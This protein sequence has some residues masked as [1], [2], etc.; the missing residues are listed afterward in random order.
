VSGHEPAAGERAP[1][2]AARL[3]RLRHGGM[4]W[5]LAAASVREVVGTERLQR[6]PRATAGAPHGWLLGEREELP[7]FL[8]AGERLATGTGAI[9]VVQAA[10]GPDCGLAVEAVEEVREEPISRLRLLPALAAARRWA[11]PRVVLWDDGLALEIAPEAVPYLAGTAADEEARRQGP[12]LAPPAGTPR[13]EVPP[14]RSSS[15]SGL[16]LFTLPGLPAL[17]CA[18]PAA[19]VVEVMSSFPL[20]PVPGVP[21][22]F[23]GLC[24][25]RG[26]PLP[27][28]DLA[29][30][31]G[32]PPVAPR[33]RRFAHGLVARAAHSRQLL[34]FPLES[35]TGVRQGPF[36]YP[37]AGA[38]PF[39]GAHHLLGS[40]AH[41]EQPLV[42]PDLDGVLR[43]SPAAT[44]T[45]A[46][47]A[48]GMP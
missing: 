46:A 43:A 22:P 39:P 18:L 21:E 33:A 14:P 12:A 31:L 32:L 26:E 40:F 25:W 48:G 13:F 24:A 8:L 9:V 20:R 11:F 10:S 7:V 17:G 29:R 45:P 16:C 37:P 44:Q 47:A 38:S 2:P 15:S 6:H 36:P 27:V 30:A 42:V 28:L 4:P 35:M 34:V 19:Q 41:G 5:A 1:A 3:L 23:L